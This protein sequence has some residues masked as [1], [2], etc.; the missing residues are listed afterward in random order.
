LALL[1]VPFMFSV[2]YAARTSGF[3]FTSSP[4][5]LSTTNTVAATLAVTTATSLQPPA[6]YSDPLRRSVWIDGVK[7][8][9]EALAQPGYTGFTNSYINVAA[10]HVV[11]FCGEVA[12]T[13][14]YDSDSGA[15]RF[16]SIFGQAQ[17]TQVES[18]D[19][20]FD[21]LWNRACGH[22]SNSAES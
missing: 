5:S 9:Q 6:V 1:V 19:P 3:S 17:A 15:Q 13:S 2:A 10:G 8:V 14:G 21:V 4:S 11:S 16:V 18:N 20:S 12:G 22:G 7:S